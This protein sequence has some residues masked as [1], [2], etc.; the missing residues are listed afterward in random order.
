MA[1][2]EYE[3]SPWEPIADHVD[4]YLE[5]G[6]EEGGV[7]EGARAVILT[8]TG[9]KT[10]KL[11]RTPLIRVKDGDDYLVVA[12]LGGAPDHP[13]W[14][15]NLV[16]NPDVT[17]HDMAEVHELRARVASPEEKAAR[18]PAATAVWPD[19]DVYQARTE[20]DIPLVV[21]EPR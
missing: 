20:R 8:T 4:R 21:L 19:Y 16:A 6:G 15:L 17:I 18:W 12:S 14:Y 2:P 1:D 7:W 10:G 13:L 5:T 11:R 3:P 9:R